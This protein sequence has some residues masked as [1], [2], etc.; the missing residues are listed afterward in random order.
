VID[1]EPNTSVT[2]T[3]VSEGKAADAVGPPRD[4]VRTVVGVPVIQDPRAAKAKAAESAKM[5]AASSLG[6]PKRQTL[7]QFGGAPSE[8]EDASSHS[9][10]RASAPIVVPAPGAQA[11]KNAVTRPPPWGEGAVEIGPAIPKSPRLPRLRDESVEELSGS[12]LVEQTEDGP[13]FRRLSPSNP[14]PGPRGSVPPKRSSGSHGANS[15]LSKGASAPAAGASPSR[16]TGAAQADRT[17]P[18][19]VDRTAPMRGAR[20]APMPDRTAPMPV[21]ERAASATKRS[22]S[23]AAVGYGGTISLAGSPEAPFGWMKPLFNRWPILHRV[24]QGK[25]RFFLPVLFGM[26]FLVVLVGFGSVIKALV[27][28]RDRSAA[29]DRGNKG[30][31][32]GARVAVTTTG[33]AAA[34][35]IDS[36]K[37]AP[38]T[39][40]AP[41]TEA[42]IEVP[43][44]ATPCSVVGHSK[45]IAPQ[46]LVSSG[47]EVV[48]TAQGIALGFA[49]APKE[50]VTM[51]V[52]PS[53]LAVSS[54]RTLKSSDLVRRVTPI[55][56][57]DSH[58]P[59][60]KGEAPLAFATATDRKSDV[61][62]G[63][64]VASGTSPIDFGV[65]TGH[66]VWASH[67]SDKTT[68]LWSLAGDAP[69][70][71]LR[72]VPLEGSE[73]GY[74]LTFRRDGAIWTGVI[75]GT[76]KSL[77]TRGDLS[78]S[79][80]LGPQVGSPSIATSG[81]VVFVLWADRAS[82][83]EPW[84]LRYQRWRT[85]E[86]PEPARTFSAP[87]GGLGAPYMSPSVTALGGG[88]FLVVWTEGPVSSHQVRALTLDA[89][90]QAQG[91]A[92]TVSSD[93][94]NAGQ[95]QAAVMADGRG[96]VAYL[97]ADG[98]GFELMAT[99]V[100]CPRP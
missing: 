65:A 10:D 24:Q 96:A 84:G 62:D 49:S 1:P 63:R 97:V 12:M 15:S 14:P 48:P 36:A 80:G 66:L 27:S 18:M 46:V 30:A 19:P 7:I 74:A 16:S 34:A 59:S 43:A 83:D 25:P 55:P 20:A 54:D 53:S 37:A 5:K 38:A 6:K 11:G 100:S 4:G 50:A 93:A 17:A 57:P 42:D 60:V 79:K 99:S 41:S 61:I 86:A 98:R 3:A 95:G 69:V 82:A 77:A 52:D 45:P 31:D 22:D 29:S 89:D 75:A 33:S 26:V 47:V 73:H 85:H 35:T 72:A 44:G 21:Y 78:E 8:S 67:N 39:S 56:P 68:A 94:A 64:R 81:D 88:R 23:A 76:D 9:G 90:G 40:A 2:L 71:A 92:F 91:P 32:P 87:T 51:L 58:K 28:P 13:T 70:E